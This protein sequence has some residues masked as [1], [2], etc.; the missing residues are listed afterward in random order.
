MEQSST[1]FNNFYGNLTFINNSDYG[2]NYLSNASPLYDF[3]E[4]DLT[5]INNST[6]NISVGLGGGR[7]LKVQGILLWMQ[8]VAWLILIT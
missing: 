1:N 5:V 4:G 6:A 3:V 7:P 8:A 2:N